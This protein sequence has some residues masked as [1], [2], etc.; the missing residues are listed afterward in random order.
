MLMRYVLN[1]SPGTCKH[2]GALGRL[3]T[4]ISAWGSALF[5]STGW[6]MPEPQ[7]VERATSTAPTLFISMCESFIFYIGLG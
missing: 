2:T 7:S 1:T 4:Y 6:A 5:V 3:Y